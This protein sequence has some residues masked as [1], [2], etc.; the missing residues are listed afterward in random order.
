MG[1]RPLRIL[2]G[3]VLLASGA[4]MVAGSAE[5]WA[6]VCAPGQ[7]ESRACDLRQDHLYDFLPPG[8]PW[9]P[10]GDAAEL[11]GW[12]LLALSLALPLLPWALTGHRPR[13]GVSIAVAASTAAVGAVGLATLRSGLSGEVVEPT[14]PGLTF[15]TWLFLPPLVFGVLAA[16][17]RGL[18]RASAVLLV[19]GTPLVAAFSYAIGSYDAA[20]WW[21][22]VAGGLTG[23]AGVVLL[24]AAPRGS[25]QAPHR[26][27]DAAAVVLTRAR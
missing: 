9:Q 17:A 8:D 21:E 27:A 4:L 15:N 11:A 7:G 25:G 2:E 16:R 22:A 1:L 18:T 5:R 23:L 20:P 3:L 6:D 24:V 13:L 19:V 10:I 12:S 26:E 14:Y